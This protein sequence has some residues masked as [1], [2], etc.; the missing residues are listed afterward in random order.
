MIAQKAKDAEAYQQTMLKEQVRFLWL[1]ERVSASSEG[2]K[3]ELELREH[4]RLCF[5]F[6]PSHNVCDATPVAP[7]LSLLG[8][9]GWRRKSTWTR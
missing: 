3:V 7:A 4:T 6:F 8:A 5:S 2:S 1:K 9:A